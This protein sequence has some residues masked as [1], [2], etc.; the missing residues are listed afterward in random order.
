MNYMPFFE[1]PNQDLDTMKLV[2]V[3]SD[4]KAILFSLLEP[5]SHHNSSVS[6][7]V[8]VKQ[9]GITNHLQ[10]TTLGKQVIVTFDSDCQQYHWFHLTRQL[11]SV[12]KAIIIKIISCCFCFDLAA[13][14]QQ[15]EMSTFK[16]RSKLRCIF[17]SKTLD[18]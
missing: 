12:N 5:H 9:D 4:D 14:K 3:N 11:V 13:R 17:R 1:L 7:S 16:K 15:L 6:G 10:I 2:A 8:L 18:T